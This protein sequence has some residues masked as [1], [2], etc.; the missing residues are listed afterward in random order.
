LNVLHVPFHYYPEAVGGTEVYVS[1]LA[2]QL[3]KRGLSVA[4]AAPA[5]ASADY[6]HDGI[7]VYRFGVTKSPADVAALYGE[8]DPKATADFAR[9]LDRRRPDLVH[10]HAM[11]PAVSLNVLF[12]QNA[13]GKTNLIEARWIVGSTLFLAL[14]FL[15]LQN[16]DLVTLKFYHWWSWQAPL[17]FVVLI[18]FAIGAT[19]ALGAPL[20]AIEGDGSAMYSIQALWTAA[21]LKRPITYLICNN[22]SYR[23]LKERLVSMRGTE[24]FIGMD[25]RDPEI[26]FVALSQSMGVPAK[27]ISDAQDVVPALR[28]AIAGGVPNLLDISVADGFGN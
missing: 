23:I 19:V 9:I 10:L 5:G 2:N 8:G 26:D 15:S 27:R 3:Q 6:L 4:V 20:A 16:S 14:L 17:I 12:G 21:N 25:L 1:L 22:R 24:K 7:Q 28:G 11:S 13:Q 18:A